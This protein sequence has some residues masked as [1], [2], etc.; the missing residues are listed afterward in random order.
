MSLRSNR[1]DETNTDDDDK[2]IPIERSSFIIKN[3]LRICLYFILLLI[4]IITVCVMRN[5]PIESLSW[6]II[7]IIAIVYVIIICCMKFRK[8]LQR[9]DLH[10]RSKNNLTR[11]TMITSTGLSIFVILFAASVMSPM[12]YGY[13]SFG[14]FLLFFFYMVT[15]IWILTLI[16][17]FWILFIRFLWREFS[18][19]WQELSVGIISFFCASFLI[20]IVFIMIIAIPTGSILLSVGYGFILTFSIVLFIG[21]IISAI[22]Y[23][24]RLSKL[25]SSVLSLIGLLMFIFLLWFYLNDGFIIKINV[26]IPSER[27]PKHFTNDPSLN[28]NYSYAFLTYGS[29][30]DQRDDYGNKASILTP[31]IDLSSLIKISSFNKKFF[32][33]NESSLPLNGRIWYPTDKTRSYP[34]VLMVHGNHLSTK[35]SENGYDYLGQMLASQGFIAISI[36][37]NFLNGAPVTSIG[38]GK[39]SKIKEYLFDTDYASEYIAR[40]ILILET[41]KQ[42][43]RWNENQTNIF[44]QQLDFSNIGLMGHSRGGETIV[45]AYLINQLKYLPEY[46]SNIHFDNYNFNIKVLFSIGGTS[47]H[48]MPLGRNLKFSDVTLFALHGVYDGDVSQFLSQTQIANLKF[49]SNSSYHFKSSLYVHQA[50]HGQFNNDWGRY[51]WRFGT[52]RFI[53]IRPLMKM[54]EQQHICKIYMSALMKIGLKNQLEYRILFED[55]RSVKNY[56]PYTNY[57]STF[58]DSNEIV[59]ADFENYDL[60]K[61]T[62]F[63][64]KINVSN[65]LLWSSVYIKTYHSAMLLIQP[66]KNSTGSYKIQ[67]SNPLN[68]SNI[69]FMIGR[70]EE[71]LSDYLVVRVFY[72]NKI[73]DSFNVRVLP[74]LTKQVFKIS[75]EEYVFAVQTISLPILQPIIGLELIVNGTDAQFLIDNIVI[76]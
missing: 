27:F 29:G 37:E 55:Y 17:Y 11:I 43:R 14:T 26:I 40:G 5:L 60:T 71:G 44:Y 1:Y 10:I 25:L 4:M 59:I 51:D 8:N 39:I 54:D 42:L 19:I 24:V 47:D 35:S 21:G 9:K 33:F 2:I 52:D 76:V 38:Y 18:F 69:R 58:Q 23:N 73:F 68:G 36:D 3:V 7:S 57:I 41:L 61:G 28:G 64:S 20:C 15:F 46:P 45:I 48:Y 75:L 72:D 49:T 12:N 50:N 16:I 22:V 31:T 74:A 56:L 30:I 13:G 70:T 67:L 62:I 66:I 65:L 6:I 32:K 63:N 34:I 53:N